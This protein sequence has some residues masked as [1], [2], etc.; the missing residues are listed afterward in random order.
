M[1]ELLGTATNIIGFRTEKGWEAALEL[2]IITSEP[3]FRI[4][5]GGSFIKE[6]VTQTSRIIVHGETLDG[7]ITRLT[8]FRDHIKKIEEESTE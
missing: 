8:E 2:I 4:D 1:Q 5:S 3:T 7:L 6:R